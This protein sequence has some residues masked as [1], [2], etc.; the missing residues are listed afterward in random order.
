MRHLWRILLALLL[1]S[2]CRRL[3]LYDESGSLRLSMEIDLD[4]RH[5]PGIEAPQTMSV[6]FFAPETGKYLS[7]DYVGADGGLLDVAAGIYDMLAF[8]FG[9]ETTVIRNAGNINSIE[10]YTETV[11]FDIRD[12]YD[13]M[14]S[15]LEAVGATKGESY[16]GDPVVF[17]PDHLFVANIRGLDVPVR[18]EGEDTMTVHAVA[19]T[20]LEAYSIE[21]GPVKG[22]EYI[23]GAE[24]FLT[25]Q[26][27]SAFVAT[28]EHP[29]KKATIYFPIQVDRR[30]FMFR[31]AFNTFGKYPGADNKVYLN[32]LIEDTG[33]GQYQYR[34]DVTDQFDNPDNDEGRIVIDDLIDIPEP[35]KGGGGFQPDVSDWSDEIYDI[36]L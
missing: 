7:S 27:R 31:T 28:G 2:G 8:N 9:T 36:E 16:G 4:I 15:R 35:S 10:A 29:D 1:L 6:L 32:I 33:G 5:N 13:K 20:I 11:S 34:Y 22:V 17:E 21:I 26:R 25:G 18:V 12:A 24:V 14:E 19:S 30:D 3:P 23:R